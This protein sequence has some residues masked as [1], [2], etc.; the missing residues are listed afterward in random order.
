MSDKDEVLDALERR[1]VPPAK[2]VEKYHAWRIGR[3]V[4]Y[5][6][7][8]L[9]LV[10][11]VLVALPIFVLKQTPEKWLLVFAG[12]GFLG[13]L[14]MVFIGGVTASGEAM[15]AAGEAGGR[16]ATVLARAVKAVKEKGTS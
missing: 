1:G 10:S 8:A 11:F 13:G 9:A 16:L 4:A 7:G 12:V 2:A 6:G 5:L 3:A 15:A 14:L